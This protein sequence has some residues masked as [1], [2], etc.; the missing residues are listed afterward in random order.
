MINFKTENMS[1]MI[2]Y[3]PSCC[4]YKQVKGL[5]YNCKSAPLRNMVHV[6]FCCDIFIDFNKVNII[7]T[8][9]LLVIFQDEHLLDGSN[10]CLFD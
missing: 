8:F 7:I 2:Y 9:I 1:Y 10:L 4:F 6:S 3:V 5:H